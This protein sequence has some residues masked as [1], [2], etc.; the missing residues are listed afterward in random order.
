MR[1]LILSALLA[2]PLVA[3]ADCFTTKAS[4]YHNKFNGRTTANGETFSNSKLTAAHKTLPF[5]TVLDVTHGKRTVRVRI[6]DRGPFIKGRGID[7][8]KAAMREIG[9]V[10]RGVV[11]VTACIVQ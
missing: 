9:G 5:G 4:Y 2:A 7:L 10:H 11:R 3:Q 8:S 6:N 1:R